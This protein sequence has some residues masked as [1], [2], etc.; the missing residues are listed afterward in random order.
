MI[1]F[2][3]I[4]QRPLM[5]IWVQNVLASC[6]F[7]NTFLFL[8]YS[9]HLAKVQNHFN[10]YVVFRYAFYYHANYGH[11]KDG[12]ERMHYQVFICRKSYFTYIIIIEIINRIITSVPSQ[13]HSN[14]SF[15]SIYLI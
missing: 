1:V 13:L 9:N 11:S 2:P 8:D 6:G 15:Q 5:E 3:L 10:K 7:N 12:I 14:I 4:V